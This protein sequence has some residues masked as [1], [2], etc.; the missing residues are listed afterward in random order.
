MVEISRVRQPCTHTFLP[1]DVTIPTLS[2]HLLNS[3]RFQG[4]PTKKQSFSR[5]SFRPHPTNF[6]PP[7]SNRCTANL[8][9]GRRSTSHLA[10]TMC[11]TIKNTR[12]LC[13]ARRGCQPCSIY[14]PDREMRPP[15][16]VSMCDKVDAFTRVCHGHHEVEDSQ[17][18][19]SIFYKT[20][21]CPKHHRRRMANLQEAW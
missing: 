13:H 9:P 3:R 2:P 15:P 18:E 16:F 4:Q 5:T 7:N 21:E 20:L 11:K 14:D 1:S 12:W 8:P 6:Y 17:D 19:D 10:Q